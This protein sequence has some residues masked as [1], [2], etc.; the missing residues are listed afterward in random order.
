MDLR[1]AFGRVLRDMRI[2]KK[3]TQDDL[4]E[5][6]ELARTYISL[7]ERGDK[8][9]TLQTIFDLAEGLECRPEDMIAE[10][11]KII[12]KATVSR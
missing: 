8:Q 3:L 10:V 12:K 9:P 2:E 4:S 11:A 1:R 6:A 5:R 7:L